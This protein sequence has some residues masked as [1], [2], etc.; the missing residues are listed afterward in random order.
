[1]PVRPVWLEI[2]SLGAF[3]TVILLCMMEI[4]REAFRWSLTQKTVT[5]LLVWILLHHV[6]SSPCKINLNRYTYHRS[7]EEKI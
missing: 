1:M 2:T 3:G 5:V 4:E 7:H 6:S